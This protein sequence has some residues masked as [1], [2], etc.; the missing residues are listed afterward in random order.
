LL[1][2]HKRELIE[3]DPFG[4]VHLSGGFGQK[5]FR[6]GDLVWMGISPQ[7][8]RVV[9]RLE[10]EI[11]HLDYRLNHI[12]NVA[13]SQRIFPENAALD[14]WGRL[15]LYS[16]TYNSIFIFDKGELESTPFVNFSK[17]FSSVFCLEKMNINQDGDMALLDCK[18]MI[19]FFS[20][21]GQKQAS[22]PTTIDGATFLVPVRN[23]WFV[24]NQNGDGISVL[25][26]ERVSI[27]GASLPV[28]DMVSMNRS[29]AVLSKDHILVLDVK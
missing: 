2:E 21:N 17:E 11:V 13:L 25:S 9:D 16:R 18:G 3:L 26:Q 27:P 23:D 14:P 28:E 1:D 10:N 20:R 8:I 5:S 19:H 29:I 7:G 4:E 22:F 12:H 6:F 24:F 15:Y